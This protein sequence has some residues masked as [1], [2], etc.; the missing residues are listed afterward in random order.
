ML[1]GGYRVFFFSA[2]RR[3]ASDTVRDRSYPTG[4]TRSH[5]SMM[6]DESVTGGR[7]VPIL[8]DHFGYRQSGGTR[9]MHGETARL[10]NQRL[11]E[12]SS[13]GRQLAWLL[14]YHQIVDRDG[15]F[16]LQN[17]LKYRPFAPLGRSMSYMLREEALQGTGNDG[18]SRIV[19]RALIP[20]G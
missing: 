7:C 6:I 5:P 4:S 3:A 16:Q 13:R 9:T 8:L 1:S 14:T 2:Q 12:R 10:R 19:R 20:D 18:L 15:K 17:V 11:L